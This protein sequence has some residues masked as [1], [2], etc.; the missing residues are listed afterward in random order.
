MWCEIFLE[1]LG[2]QTTISRTVALPD[3][4]KNSLHC[5]PSSVH[6]SNY[7]WSHLYITASYKSIVLLA[8]IYKLFEW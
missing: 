2:K 1:R 5:Y 8:V 4:K 3:V 6:F 7:L